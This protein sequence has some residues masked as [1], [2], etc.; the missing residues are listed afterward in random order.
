MSVLSLSETSAEVRLLGAL[1]RPPDAVSIG[2]A[3]IEQL[4]AQVGDWQRF[5]D[6]LI[7]H[8][9]VPIAARNSALV[10]AAGIPSETVEALRSRSGSNAREAFRYLVVLKPLLELLGKDGI[11]PVILKG[12]PLS[13]IAYGDVSAR[14]VGDIDLLI[15]QRDALRADDIFQKSGMVR[16][17]PGG[18]LTPKRASFYLRNFKDFTYEAQPRG[19]EVDM[20]WR[21]IR[22]SAT[23]AAILPPSAHDSFE[24]LRIGPLNLQVLSIDRTLLFLS[25][26][27]AMEGWARWKTLADMAALWTKATEAQRLQ[28]WRCARE[29]S[30]T[31]FL[32]AALTLAG[33]WFAMDCGTD[34]EAEL[35]RAAA[36]ERR[37]ATYIVTHA[38][39]AVLQ[40]GY[41][42]P[43]AGDS[44]FAM[45]LHEYRLHPSI[46]ARAEL[47]RRILFRP[48]I[49]ETVNLPDFLFPLYSLLSPIEWV[50]FRRRPTEN[51]TGRK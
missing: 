51:R 7:Y 11:H 6:L 44:T 45:K 30:A 29:S 22:D 9:L 19:F 43:P 50:S 21:L 40:H 12:V 37:L 4:V 8:R 16:K 24:A 10:K 35:K 49:W 47:A 1:C 27:G 34:A 42:P 38:G 31:G 28:T 39:R 3:S 15:D 5:L 14:D 46:A 18:R 17:E 32:A 48:R 41:K 26:H 33:R 13:Y 25:A 36:N 20:H 2:H 23:A